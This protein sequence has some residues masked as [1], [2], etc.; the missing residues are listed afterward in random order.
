MSATM[1]KKLES[2]SSPGMQERVPQPAG[3]HN[4]HTCF[5]WCR[6]GCRHGLRHVCHKLRLKAVRPRSSS[7]SHRCL[8]EAIISRPPVQSSP[9]TVPACQPRFGR[10]ASRLACAMLALSMQRLPAAAFCGHC[11]GV[12]VVAKVQARHCSGRPT[13]C[14]SAPSR[15]AAHLRRC[16][17]G[18]GVAW[19]RR[20]T[21]PLLARC[22]AL[23]S[24]QPQLPHHCVRNLRSSSVDCTVRSQCERSRCSSF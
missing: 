16:R 10:S 22:E 18:A 9:V 7:R 11:S 21:V 23:Q 3:P 13:G 12:A 4:C 19:T 24:R 20:R 17:G 6:A 8:G 15:Q 14:R 2:I 1:Y 5:L